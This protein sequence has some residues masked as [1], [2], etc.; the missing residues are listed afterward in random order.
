MAA[1]KHE[2][3]GF[4]VTV[5]YILIP[6]SPSTIDEPESAM[7]QTK[8]RKLKAFK[9]GG[10][11]SRSQPEIRILIDVLS[12]LMVPIIIHKLSTFPSQAMVDADAEHNV[13]VVPPHS[14]RT[15]QALASFVL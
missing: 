7:F 3:T 15:T 11:L 4:D 1:S 5:R 10:A 12:T 8:C 6:M 2:A 9:Q 14:S 13:P